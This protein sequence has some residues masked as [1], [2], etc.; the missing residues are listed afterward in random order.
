MLCQ[1]SRF[2]SSWLVRLG[3]VRDTLTQRALNHRVIHANHVLHVSLLVALILVSSDVLLKATLVEEMGTTVELDC[4]LCGVVDD[5][6][7]TKLFNEVRFP[8][9]KFFQ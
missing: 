2:R 3:R 7:Q 6:I 5:T 1:I 8:F 4:A 9:G